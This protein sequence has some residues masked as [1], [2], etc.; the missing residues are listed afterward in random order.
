MT[1]KVNLLYW[2]LFF[3]V[4][5]LQAQDSKSL[6]DA[7]HYFS[8]RS[9][10]VALPKFLAA[11]QAGEK[12]PL[13]YYKTG[14][15][16]Q[17]SPETDEQ[18]KSIP[19]FEYALKN[20]KDMPASLYYDLGTM[21]LKDESLQ[22]AVQSFT[23]FREV[24]SKADKKVMAQA[25]EA[26]QTCHNAIALMSVPRNFK[27]THFNSIINTKYTEYN[28]VV[29][30]DESVMAFTALRPNTG[31]TRT[32]DKFIEE[33]YITYNINGAWSEPKVVP[34]AHDYNVGTAGIS[35]DGQKMLIFMGGATDPGGLYQISRAGDAWSKPSLITPSLNTPKYLESTASITP[36]GKTIYFAS[37]RLGGQG[38]LDIYK[39]T[40][41][42]NGSWSNPVNLGPEVNSKAN[43][44][45]PFI[46]PDQKTL[47]FT[48]DGHNSM[49]GRDIFVTR[50]VGTKWTS[51]ENMGYPVNTT[52]NDNYFT[53]I[54]DGTRAYF[55]SDRKGGMGGQDIYYIDLPAESANIPL[56]MIKGKIL[57]AE[58]GKPMPTKIYLIDNETDKKLDFVYDPDPE[59]G[60]YLV[61]LPPSKNYDM[62]IES[63]GF[64]PYTLNINIPNQTYFYELYQMVSLK[65]IKQFDVVVGQEVQVKN[66]FYDTDS[67]VKADLRK[68]H[69]AKLVQGGNVDVYDM[70][71]DL[72]AAQDKDGINYLTDLIQMKDPIEEVNFNE[73]ENSRIEMAT[74]TYYY[75]ES[76]ESKFEQKQVD[77]KT[78]FSLPTFMVNEEIMK[79]KGQTA[80]KTSVIDKAVLAKSAKIYFDAG[81]SDL[82]AQYNAQL[83]VILAELNKNP[84]LGIE[85]L[86]FASAEGTEEMNRDLSNKRAISV[87]DYINHKGVVRR[88]IVAKGYG[89][90]K[91][92]SASKEEG[93]RVEVH[94]VDLNA[95]SEIK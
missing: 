57:N 35:A 36:D 13:V 81:K 93:R 29:S 28:P 27:V 20:G 14:V 23:K 30:A 42:A 90:T 77:G 72:M 91:D 4:I 40:L 16:Y 94:I 67:D 88:R 66:A 49:G 38:G 74:R 47:F 71:L 59:T 18:I 26:I 3:S 33:I 92:Q 51:P 10:D 58:T 78:I 5:A 8:V 25:D 46:H 44:D 12:S 24:S 50:M 80:K 75:D 31:K 53:L 70:M 65:T 45:A 55:S 84:D 79:Q 56:T 21:Y 54:A 83:D 48:S 69:E 82:K 39:T 63:E 52:V 41:Q 17:K 7:E 37:D 15:C 62:V 22:N 6:A 68:T 60:N 85:I 89:A 11:I 61:I 34:I 73:K 1:R 95:L 9:Y 32:G 2:L 86:G 87:L 19:Y 64:L 43:E 76:D